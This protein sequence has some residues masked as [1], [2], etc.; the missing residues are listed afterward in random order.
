MRGKSGVV[1]TGVLCAAAL[2]GA[3]S[4]TSQQTATSSPPTTAAPQLVDVT[5]AYLFGS[6]EVNVESS[7]GNFT[8]TGLDPIDDSGYDPAD[9]GTLEVSDPDGKGVIITWDA[10]TEANVENAFVRVDFGRTPDMQYPDMV[11]TQ[12]KVTVPTRTPDGVAGSF[13]CTDLPNFGNS[14]QTLASAS[15]TFTARR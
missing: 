1:M 6:A 12:C 3:C 11:H 13:T 4:G 5:E 14:D 7:Q 8:A 10:G 2:L 15:G 9:E